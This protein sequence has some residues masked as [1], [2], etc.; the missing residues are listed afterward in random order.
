MSRCWDLY[1]PEPAKQGRWQTPK[2]P[3]DRTVRDCLHGCNA[4]ILQPVINEIHGGVC[5]ECRLDLGGVE[6]GETYAR[7]LVEPEP[8]RQKAA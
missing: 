1:G 5:P 4:V 7:W 3:R 8:G 6:W 2:A